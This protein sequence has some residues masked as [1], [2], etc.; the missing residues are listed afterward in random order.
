M[1][2]RY[3]SINRDDPQKAAEI[4][5]MVGKT[6]YLA[7]SIRE[8]ELI[9]H[10][11]TGIHYHIVTYTSN[12]KSAVIYFIQNACIIRLPLDLCENEL[13][14]NRDR[15]LRLVLAHELGHLIYNINELNT[16]AIRDRHRKVTVEEEVYT[17]A[18]AYCLIDIKSDYHKDTRQSDSFIY[19]SGDLKNSLIHILDKQVETETNLDLKREALQ[20]LW[21]EVLDIWFRY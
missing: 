15:R 10:R 19:E 17:W 2:K 11:K 12:L 5:G 13:G 4:V 3:D 16:L 18:F 8:T 6:N 20:K 14:D 21:W 1:D 9:I 7:H